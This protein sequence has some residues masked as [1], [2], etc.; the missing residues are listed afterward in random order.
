MRLSRITFF[1]FF[2]AVWDFLKIRF[3]YVGCATLTWKASRAPLQTEVREQ[4]IRD[5]GRFFI[6]LRRLQILDYAMG[7]NYL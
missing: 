5:E 7:L 1:D 4:W 2:P 6:S 3:M